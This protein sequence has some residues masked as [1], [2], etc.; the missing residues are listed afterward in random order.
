MTEEN[1]VTRNKLL[2]SIGLARKAGK[3]LLGTDVVCDAL[4]AGGVK[5]VLVSSL[6]SQNTR[7]RIVEYASA[8]GTRT[9]IISATT[10]EIG[11]AVGKRPLAC[12]GITDENFVKLIERNICKSL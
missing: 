1:N 4:K 7:K 12:M 11:S 10:D 2:N 6:A 5:L 9:E 8:Y 3:I